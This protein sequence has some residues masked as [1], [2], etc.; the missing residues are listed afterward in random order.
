MKIQSSRLR[1]CQFG[2][3]AMRTS[4]CYVITL[5]H[6]AI[7]FQPNLSGRHSTASHGRRDVV[8][9]R[10]SFVTASSTAA[11]GGVRGGESA[12]ATVRVEADETGVSDAL[13]ATVA[14]TC[15]KAIEARGA[16]TIAVPGGSALRMLAGLSGMSAWVDWSK[17]RARAAQQ[18]RCARVPPSNGWRLS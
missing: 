1:A 14:M 12:R 7:A 18:R 5:A 16:C 17:V 2:Q 8:A 13:C 6:L 4:S 9:P 11:A 3:F 10:P 15:A